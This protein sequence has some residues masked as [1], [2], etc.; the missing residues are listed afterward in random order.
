LILKQTNYLA[1]AGY[2]NH[3]LRFSVFGKF[4]MRKISDDYAL[5]FRQALPAIFAPS[6][7]WIA[8]GVKYYV[9]P[10]NFMNFTLQYERV[11]NTDAPSSEQKG[12]NNI[13]FQ[14]QTVLY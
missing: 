10:A 3:G 8:G 14:M 7:V 2:Y 11:N 9:G 4:E 5:D 1:E 13:A 6:Q 12:T